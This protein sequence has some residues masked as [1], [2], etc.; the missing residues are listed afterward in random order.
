[1]GYIV[2]T[3]LVIAKGY[4]RS[5]LYDLTRE[6][7]EYIPNDLAD[8]LT[9]G[10]RLNTADQEHLTWLLEK[11]YI[12]EIPEQV[13]GNLQPMNLEWE[14]PASI[15]NLTVSSNILKTK[16]EFIIELIRSCNIPSIAILDPNMNKEVQSFIK[17][18]E[19]TSVQVVEWLTNFNEKIDYQKYTNEFQKLKSIITYNSKKES[20]HYGNDGFGNVV[21]KTNSF[22]ERTLFKQHPSYFNVN[23]E[24]VTESHQF[25]TYFNRRLHISGNGEIHQSPYSKESF[26]SV[27]KCQTTEE[28]KEI[29]KTEKFRNFWKVTKDQIDICKDCEH[30]YMCV[31][32]REPKSRKNNTWYHETECNY[33]PYIAQWEGE[34]NYLLFSKMGIQSDVNGFSLD[35]KKVNETVKNIWGID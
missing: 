16:Q 29:L 5:V 12:L 13:Q 9:E 10:T 1:M 24:L 11:E 20:H 14:Y 30:R 6:D 2:S 18:L 25:H 23:T 4:L 31:D 21:H 34:T 26:G 22:E 15:L 33:N 17:A 8:I 7:Y 28:L 19:L 32:N 27:S 3:D 35:E